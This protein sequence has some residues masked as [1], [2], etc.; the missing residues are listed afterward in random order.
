MKK[1]LLTAF[2]F[3]FFFAFAKAQRKYAVALGAN[4]NFATKGLGT[5]DVGIG[6]VLQSTYTLHSKLLVRGEAGLDHFIGNKLLY[7][8]AAGNTYS[9][10]PTIVSVKAGPAYKIAENLSLAALY[11]IARYRYFGQTVN[12]GNYKLL[13]NA[14]LG[15][16]KKSVVGIYYSGLHKEGKG[17]HFLGTSFG[18]RIL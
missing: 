1:M 12:A 16:K 6:F 13:L 18:Y 15:Q 14:S 17:V 3:L 7:A 4:L 2:L 5:N 9:G 11:G 10:N 8:D